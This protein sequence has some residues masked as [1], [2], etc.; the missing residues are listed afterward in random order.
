MDTRSNSPI[1]NPLISA[2]TRI[3]DCIFRQARRD[4]RGFP[5]FLHTRWPSH[6]VRGQVVFFFFFRRP[7]IVNLY[8]LANGNSKIKDIP[9]DERQSLT[10]ASVSFF[11]SRWLPRKGHLA[12]LAHG[13]NRGGEQAPPFRVRTQA[14]EASRGGIRRPL[15][16]FTPPLISDPAPLRAPSV[17]E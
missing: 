10:D 5:G 15:M 6:H 7:Y 2:S 1:K 12:F 8:F 13:R 14:G 9:L 16:N 3:W 4:S 11:L 17:Q